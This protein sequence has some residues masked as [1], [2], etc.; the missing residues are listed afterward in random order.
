MFSMLVNT[1]GEIGCYTDDTAFR[2]VGWRVY[3][4]QVASCFRKKL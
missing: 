4:R 1:L 2:F 3:K